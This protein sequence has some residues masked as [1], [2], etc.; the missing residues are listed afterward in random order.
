MNHVNEIDVNVTVRRVLISVSNKSGLPELVETLITLPDVQIVSTGGTYKK[1]AEILGQKREERLIRVSSYTG[2]PEMQ[3]GLV[4]TLDFKIYLGL[5]SE[6]YNTDHDSDRARMAAELID[7]VVVNLYPFAEVISNPECDA[8]DARSNID[9]GGPTMLRAAA[10]SYLRV[11]P[12]CNPADYPTV[13]DELR[14]NGGTVSY[15]TRLKLAKKAFAHT[16]EYE[17]VIADY[18]DSLSSESA[19]APYT[20]H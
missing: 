16:A 13:C 15:Q 11:V 20:L 14:E 12:L 18:F 4:K 17:R 5:L 19:R 8:E 7:M 6:P 2:Q 1:I 10:K 9:I 3:G